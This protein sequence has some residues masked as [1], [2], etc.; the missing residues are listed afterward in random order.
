MMDDRRDRFQGL[1]SRACFEVARRFLTQSA[2]LPQD[3]DAVQ[4]GQRAAI[5]T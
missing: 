4:H 3:F 2:D 1:I 5:P